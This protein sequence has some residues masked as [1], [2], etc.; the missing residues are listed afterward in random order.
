MKAEHEL[1]LLGEALGEDPERETFA[2]AVNKLREELVKEFEKTGIPGKLLFGSKKK[3]AVLRPDF[4][5]SLRGIA[6][7][8]GECADAM[9]KVSSSAAAISISASQ[10]KEKEK[11]HGP[12]LEVAYMDSEI[13]ASDKELLAYFRGIMLQKRIDRMDLVERMTH[14]AATLIGGP[15]E[16]EMERFHAHLQTLGFDFDKAIVRYLSV[17]Y[18]LYEEHERGPIL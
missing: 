18:E 12:P 11:L 14:A 4:A 9:S 3:K 17:F 8:S 5:D 1:E 13:T 15:Q 2:A 6:K 16:W 10:M 7:A